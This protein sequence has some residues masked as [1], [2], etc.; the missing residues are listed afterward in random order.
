MR[1]YS[2]R[3]SSRTR[4]GPGSREGIRQ[5]REILNGDSGGN[6]TTNFSAQGKKATQGKESS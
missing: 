3:R 4:R 5:R 2:K 6:F 1:I